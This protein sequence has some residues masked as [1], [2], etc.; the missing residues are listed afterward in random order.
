MSPTLRFLVSSLTVS[1]VLPELSSPFTEN[2]TVV[3]ILIDIKIANK[4]EKLFFNI[5]IPPYFTTTVKGSTFTP[6][7]LIFNVDLP[8]FNPLIFK[9]EEF[10]FVTIFAY[11][12]FT[13]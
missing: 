7:T 10:L 9:V 2:G 8:F 4:T 1:A 13:Y 12:L 6:L 3:T 5:T 11:L